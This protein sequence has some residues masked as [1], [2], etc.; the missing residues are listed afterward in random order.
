MA[1]SSARSVTMSADARRAGVSRTAVSFVLN[2]RPG[3]AVPDETRRRMQTASDEL[4][5]R[6]NALLCGNDRT[7][8]GAKGVEMPAALAAGQPLDTRGATLD[9]PPLER[10]SV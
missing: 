10:S 9:C 8:M 6:T 5:Y 2:D 7:A 1:A 3:V 4:G